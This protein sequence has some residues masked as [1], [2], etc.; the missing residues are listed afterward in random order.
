MTADFAFT[1]MAQDGT[2]RAGA[3][4][5][6]RGVVRTPAFMPVGTGATVKAMFP[7][8][9][10]AAGADIVLAN[11]YH[12]MLRPG[13]ERIAKL[14]GLHRFMHW[15]KP[16]LTDSGGYQVMS[17]A[18]LRRIDLSGDYH[19]DLWVRAG[20]VT[21]VMGV[22]GEFVKGAVPVLVARALGFDILPMALAGLAAVCGQMWPVFTKFDG[23]KGNSIAIAM[24]ISL[25]PK[26]AL[27]SIIPVIIALLIR[28]VPRLIARSKSSGS[29]PVVGGSYSRALPLGMAVCFI[30][31]P[32]T[33]WYFNQPPEIIWC[34]VALF[35]LIMVR[36]LTAGLR[37]DLKASRDI[38]GV[39]V[40]RLLYDR[41]T[42]A[43]RE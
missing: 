15:E 42:A 11:T 22:L 2:A 6:P 9:V 34:C 33:S 41:A 28:T 29:E 35:A 10:A 39:I 5:S 27:I 23:E 13:A 16:I 4:T 8:D 36:R 1:V 43:W 26:P 19:Q 25:V 17:L 12:L 38:W 20:K 3:I 30:T 21:G 14:G 24:A 31:L 40:R 32:L 18:K 7:E 37:I